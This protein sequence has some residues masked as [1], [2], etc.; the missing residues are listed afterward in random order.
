MTPQVSVLLP[1]WNAE[2]TLDTALRSLERQSEHDWECL[3]VDDGAADR[4][5]S[6]A[7]SFAS[8]DPRF[9]VEPREHAGLDRWARETYGQEGP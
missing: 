4:S 2:A 5:R 9:R 1:V 8:R 7:E 6:I 3:I